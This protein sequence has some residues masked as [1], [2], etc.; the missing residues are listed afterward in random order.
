MYSNLELEMRRKNIT[1][2]QIADCISVSYDTVI[3]KFS[4]KY[5]WWRQECEKIR[6][7]FFSDMTIDYLFKKEII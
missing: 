3:K 7:E 2:K 4:G 6:D 1:K 5:D